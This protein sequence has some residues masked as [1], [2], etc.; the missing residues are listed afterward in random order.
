MYKLLKRNKYIDYFYSMELGGSLAKRIAKRILL[1]Y[2]SI[3]Q[4]FAE[5]FL[6]LNRT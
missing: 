4:N 2:Q 1:E 5:S 6:K 3:E